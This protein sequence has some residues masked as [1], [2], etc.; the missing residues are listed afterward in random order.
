MTDVTSEAAGT[1]AAASTF[2][3]QALSLPGWNQPTPSER[4]RL[5][6]QARETD[7]TRQRQRCFPRWSKAH[8]HLAWQA[9]VRVACQRAGRP[10]RHG[11]VEEPRRAGPSAAGR[12]GLT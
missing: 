11:R 3:G 8:N 5:I 4:E 10:Q 1:P 2:S 9:L 12:H 7:A 6:A